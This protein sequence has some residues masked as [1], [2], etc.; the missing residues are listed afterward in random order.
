[1]VTGLPTGLNGSF[2]AGTFTITGTPSVSGVF[3]YIVTTTGTCTQTSAN[4][5]ITVK[6]VQVPNA[7]PDQTGSGMCGITSTTL[8]ANT[9]TE[10]TGSWSIVSGTGGN[11]VS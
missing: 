1:G 8:A 3:P 11:I 6:A 5:S 7:G 2:S 4:G 9:P 10:G